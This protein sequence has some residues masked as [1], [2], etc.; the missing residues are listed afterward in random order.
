[1]S[2]APVDASSAKSAWIA[3]SAAVVA[4]IAAV[5]VPLVVAGGANTASIVNTTLTHM[6]ATLGRIESKQ[7]DL[8]ETT[9]KL[10]GRVA[11]LEERVVKL[12]EN[13]AG[14]LMVNMPVPNPGEP[15]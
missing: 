12:E 13:V 7:D 15:G 2:A 3:A 4:A 1:M 14:A 5:V 6:S 9:T 11:K 8:I 10:E